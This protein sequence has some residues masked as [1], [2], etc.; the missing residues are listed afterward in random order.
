MIVILIALIATLVKL[1]IRRKHSGLEDVN[2]ELIAQKNIGYNEYRG[3]LSEEILSTNQVEEWRDGASKS[4]QSIWLRREIQD[5]NQNLDKIV[6]NRE[7]DKASKSIENKYN[8]L[9]ALICMGA[10]LAIIGIG[11]LI[12][13][14]PVDDILKCIIIFEAVALFYVGGLLLRNNRG[15]SFACKALVG[16]A[17]VAILFLGSVCTDLINMEWSMAWVCTSALGVILYIVAA[18]LLSNKF[19]AYSSLIFVMLFACSISVYLGFDIFWCFAVM[20]GI[21]V[22]FFG[23][24][25]LSKKYKFGVFES[26]IYNMGRW[27][28]IPIALAS[29]MIALILISMMMVPIPQI[30]PYILIYGLGFLKEFVSWLM[31]KSKKD[32]IAARFFAQVLILIIT[33]LITGYNI[34]WI[35]VVIGVTSLVHAVWSISIYKKDIAEH[36]GI[37]LAFTIILL[38][39]SILSLLVMG[40]GEAANLGHR[41]AEI[42]K[43]IMVVECL[44][45]V[46]FGVWASEK[47]KING[48]IFVAIFA[49]I[50]LP[51]VISFAWLNGSSVD[52]VCYYAIYY[53]ALLIGFLVW[54]WFC[55]SRERKSNVFLFGTS[56]IVLILLTVIFCIL[57]H[58]C[59]FE[60]KIILKMVIEISLALGWYLAGKFIKKRA[61]CATG[62]YIGIIFLAWFAFLITGGNIGLA[63]AAHILGMGFCVVGFLESYRKNRDIGMDYGGQFAGIIIV[64][65]IMLFLVMTDLSQQGLI[66]AS[67]FLIEELVLFIVGTLRGW[68]W[69]RTVGIIGSIFAILY[70]CRVRFFLVAIGAVLIMVVA[71]KII[72]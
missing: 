43:S 36:R 13:V 38:M 62:F 30:W 25:V 7:S 71:N 61:L 1:L 52:L 27:S 51:V 23:I 17:L 67:L 65:I 66:C 11:V 59:L 69:M 6:E 5:N 15:L 45:L 50:I 53:V 44:A 64:S 35:G 37:E 2:E 56:L 24:S 54:L 55:A 57:S 19:I 9:N 58:L 40:M 31:T 4:Q 72:K 18:I 26:P 48:W 63:I 28:P 39:L 49:L 32:E 16:A 47:Q 60:Y 29:V 14:A 34:F 46:L 21:S 3:G 12:T 10:F 33:I 70:F 8:R 20:M 41:Q 42:T 68:G 22:A